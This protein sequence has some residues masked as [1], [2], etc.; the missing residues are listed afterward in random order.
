LYRRR[1]ATAE[2]QPF[3]EE[4]ALRLASS[5]MAPGEANSG[6]TFDDLN[7][8]FQPLKP[9]VVSVRTAAAPLGVGTTTIWRLVGPGGGSELEVLRIGRRTL[10][11]FASVERLVA[12]GSAPSRQT[13]GEAP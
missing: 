7:P 1:R 12:S 10:I 8:N 6:S 4:E 13:H 11:T 5:T 2:N 9:L 3:S